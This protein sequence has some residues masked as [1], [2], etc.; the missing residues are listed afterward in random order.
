MTVNKLVPLYITGLIALVLTGACKRAPQTASEQRAT[1]PSA[2]RADESA[3]PSS[4]DAPPAQASAAGHSDLVQS[5]DISPDAGFVATAG[6]D[7]LAKVWNVDSGQVVTQFEHGCHDP[8]GDPSIYAVAVSPDASHVAVA[9]ARQVRIWATAA[10]E[11]PRT[12]E[13]VGQ[14]DAPSRYAVEFG[15][16]GQRIA[17]VSWEKNGHGVRIWN[18]SS[19]E[20][21][22]EIPGYGPIAFSPDGAAVAV[23]L[24]KPRAEM[25]EQ[26]RKTIALNALLT[27]RH[28]NRVA[29]F[30]LESVSR[31]KVLQGRGLADDDL[32]FDQTGSLVA[33][34]NG[35]TVTVWSVSTAKRRASATL[36][37]AGSTPWSSG[38]D[39]LDI[40]FG[41][42][43]DDVYAASQSGSVSRISVSDGTV[44]TLHS[45]PIDWGSGDEVVLPVDHPDLFY[46]R[47]QMFRLS[48]DVQ[49][50]VS[51]P[52][53]ATVF[54]WDVDSGQ[55]HTLE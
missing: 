33:A 25:T 37:L 4:A 54:V 2:R 46:F 47:E 9:C 39:V 41:P 31:Q 32:T 6:V 49:R 26:E 11:E 40:A 7:G 44:D 22:S 20:L 10:D 30:D 34:T 5:V 15:P 16:K 28:Q 36:E 48:A 18:V 1:D 8:H 17:T 12:L 43:S 19:G 24:E 50:L 3:D 52:G 21:L 55:L 53:G 38:E 23:N 42:D 45:H 51:A 27:P 13:V 35:S 29:I 14:D